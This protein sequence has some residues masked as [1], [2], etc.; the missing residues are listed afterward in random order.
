MEKRTIPHLNAVVLA[1]GSGQRFWPLSRELRPK[2]LLSLFGRDSLVVQALK[3]VGPFIDEETG[4]L[5][6]VTGEQIAGELA[7]HLAS[8]D[9]LELPDVRVLVEPSGRNTAPA[10]ALAAAELVRRD[11]DALMIV[12]P[13]DH[14]LE[15]GAVWSDAVSAGA[16][17][18]AG[19]RLVT[20]GIR[21]DRVET[22]YGYIKIGEPIEGF[23]VGAAAPHRA[24]RFVEK[25][26]RET[27]EAFIESG[28]YLWNAGI[29][30]FAASTLL[31]E[32]GA[33]SEDGR[34]I[35]AAVRGVAELPVEEWTTDAARESFAAASRAAI[36][37]ALME[38][39]D[40]VVTIPSELRWDDVGSLLALERVSE[41]D[42]HGN[43]L[44][45]RSVE[46]DSYDSVV[47]STGRLVAALGVS[48]MLIVDTDDATLVCP[49]DRAQDVRSVVERLIA[50]GANEVVESRTGPRP[51][52]SW[53]VLLEGEGFKIKR[54]EVAP[55]RRL[56]LQRH[57]QR[58]EHWVVVQ[59]RALVTRDDDVLEVGVNESTF[60]PAGTAHRLEN[61]GDH[62][63][64]IIEVQ[65]GEY[66]GEDDIE[67]LSDDWKR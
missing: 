38:R 33:V 65:V 10:I 19:G 29:F 27:A 53:T 43:V 12:L 35:V 67:R 30:V 1:G 58:S 64:V 52:G 37:R 50:E 54:I 34:A 42:E 23:D 39:S 44:A 48:D 6:I 41:T 21:P 3:R 14:L 61:P 32:L 56:S 13:S 17:L 26:D 63:L 9:E 55:G 5:E 25:P 4:G 20:I 11:P 46:V 51:W 8:C 36:D 47:Y 49:K 15:A 24:D 31:S 22:G 66:V 60:I 45:G 7:S 59:G 62:A 18:A 40:K 57:A 2:Q 16:R 28:D